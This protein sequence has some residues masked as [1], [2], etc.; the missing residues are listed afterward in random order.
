MLFDFSLASDEPAGPR[1]VMDGLLR[2]WADA[3]PRDRVTVFG[4]ASLGPRV[5]DLGFAMVE[6]RIGSR[7]GLLIEPRRP[8][9]STPL[10][11]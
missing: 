2:G 4:P 6:A 5:T 1:T 7:N 10:L 8:T 9:A 3:H 11:G